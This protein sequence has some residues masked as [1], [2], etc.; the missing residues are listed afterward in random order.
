MPQRLV[1]FFHVYHNIMLLEQYF[2]DFSMY[3]NHLVQQWL[4]KFNVNRNHQFVKLQVLSQQAAGGAWESEFLT[5][6]QV[7][8]TSVSGPHLENWGPTVL[9]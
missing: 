3:K 4:S 9:I 7:M 8:L 6:S 5:S 1:F 2:L